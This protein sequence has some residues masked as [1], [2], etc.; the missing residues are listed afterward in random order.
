VSATSVRRI[1]RRHGIG[2]APR[3][4]RGPSW[5]QFLRAQTAGTLA[6][7]FFTVETVGLTRLYVLFVVE[8]NRRRVHL[9]G[10]TAHPTGAWVA[11]QARNL[12]MDLDG[13][14]SR[15][16]F[17]I[18]DRDTK[19]TAAFDVVFA[20]AGIEV[21]RIPPRSPR[22]N[23]YAERWV[24]TART[25]GLDWLLIRN[26]AHLHRVLAI[27]PE[28]YHTARPHRSLDLQTPLEP[29][30]WRVTADDRADRPSRRAPP[31][32]PARRLTT[33]RRNPFHSSCRSTLDTTTISTSP[34]AQPGREDSFEFATSGLGGHTRPWQNM[35]H[36]LRHQP[37]VEW[38]PSASAARSVARPAGQTR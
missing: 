33:A 14:A 23:A 25:E 12:L 21:L 36:G 35:R 24:R 10:I 31:P 15:F 3:R 22:A 16:R 34:P 30:R 8:V 27:L 19:F 20:A 28:H 18:R 37:I 6:C 38:H 9:V 2:P 29:P 11:R 32:I 5:A 17:L 26:A 7:D 4:H 13:Q 1:L